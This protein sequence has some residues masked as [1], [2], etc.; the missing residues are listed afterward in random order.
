[1]EGSRCSPPCARSGAW[2]GRSTSK[3]AHGRGAGSHA[4]PRNDSR[5]TPRVPDVPPLVE[6]ADHPAHDAHEADVGGHD[7]LIGRVFG[8][9]LDVAVAALEPL[10]GGVAI[11]EGDDDRTVGGFLLRLDQDEVAVEDARV[12]HAF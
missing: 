7:R 9:E 10:Y 12:D 1:M 2:S 4:M 6:E 5:P 8:D 3:A 11:D